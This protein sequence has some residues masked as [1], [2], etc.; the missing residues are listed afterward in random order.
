MQLIL[1]LYL[2]LISSMNF[3]TN[4][5][6]EICD[7]IHPA[8]LRPCQFGFQKK[9]ST[10]HPLSLF[11]D[12]VANSLNK[13]EHSIAI[14]CDLKKAFDTVDHKLLIKKTCKNW[15]QKLCFTLV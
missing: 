2:L 12:S 6:T 10:I 14:F 13:K 11:V 5:A 7:T 15:H 1:I 3:F 4:I 9:H 8:G